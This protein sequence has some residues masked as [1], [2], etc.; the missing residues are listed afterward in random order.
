M[1]LFHRI[2]VLRFRNVREIRTHKRL[3]VVLHIPHIAVLRLAQLILIYA[4]VDAEN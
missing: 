4:V 3:E 2:H 1:L